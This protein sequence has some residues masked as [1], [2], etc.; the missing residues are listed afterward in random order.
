MQPG[1][2]STFAPERAEFSKQLQE[3]FLRQIFRFSGVPRHAQAQRV[4]AALV[5]VVEDLEGLRT[6]AFRRFN[7][8][9]L[10]PTFSR[11]CSSAQ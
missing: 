5:E 4:D 7:R 10:R 2:K 8:S 11:C 9:G 1:R 3:C 6:S